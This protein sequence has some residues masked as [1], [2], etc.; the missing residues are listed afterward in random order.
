MGRRKVTN[1]QCEHL[2]TAVSSGQS[3]PSSTQWQFGA[4]RCV[5]SMTI[6]AYYRKRY[7]SQGVRQKSGT[8]TSEERQSQKKKTGLQKGTYISNKHTILHNPIFLCK[9]T[10]IRGIS[11]KSK[12]SYTQQTYFKLNIV[13]QAVSRQLA[14]HVIESRA[15]RVF[16]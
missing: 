10:K 12:D 1:Q 5:T 14:Q 15:Q 7:F 2:N 11:I 4:Q 8:D 3:L 9:Y 13:C 16:I 6:G